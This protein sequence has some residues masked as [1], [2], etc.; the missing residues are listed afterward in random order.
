MKYYIVKNKIMPWGSYGEMLWQGTYSYD[1][2]T[3]SHMVFRTGA[4]CPSIYRSQYNRDFPVLV[5]KEDALQFIIDSN[6]TGFVLKPITKEKIVK[7]DWENWDLQAPE[8]LVYPSGD[9]DAEKYIT[10]RKHNENVA[11]QMGNLYALIP[12]KDGLLYCEQE[13]SLGRLIEQSLSG[14]DIFIDRLRCYFCS[15]I[16]ISEKTKDILSKLYSNILV[17]Q[18][19]ATF[20]ADEEL[21]YQMEQKAEQKEYEKQRESEMTDADWQKWFQ[22]KDGAKKLIEG[23]PCLKM[24]SAKSKRKINIIEKL[25][26][27]NKIYPLKY[28][29]WMQ[30]YWNI[31]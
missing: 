31:N 25:S 2:D 18:E 1:K 6:L 28:E 24:E 8:P 23:L 10:Q 21:F 19:V 29:H 11:E 14:L 9:M 7:L 4:F 20:V 17:F 15:E 30:E 26:S 22:L 16:F 12:Q 5:V 13:R 27:A 3:D